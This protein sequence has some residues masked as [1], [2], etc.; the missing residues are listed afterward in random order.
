MW[1]ARPGFREKHWRALRLGGG[2]LLLLALLPSLLQA[3]PL[4][5]TPPPIIISEILAA[6]RVV[7]DAEGEWL[8]LA[9]LGDQPVDL[10]HWSLLRRD[11]E[12]HRIKSSLVIAPGSYVVLARNGN[13]SQNGGVQP[14][15]VYSGLSLGNLGD[16]LELFTPDNLLVDSIAWGDGTALQMNEGASLERIIQD[17][18]WAVAHSSWP[19]SAGD[20]G[21]PGAPYLPPPPPPTPTPLPTPTPA[22]T[23]PPAIPPRLL[24]SEVMIDPQ[25]VDD[26]QGEWVEL[27]NAD[28]AAV[29]LNGWQLRDQDHDQH[30]VTGDLWI[31]P[32]QYLVLA[33][34]GDSGRNG[35]VSPAYVYTGLEMGNEGDELGLVTPWGIE[36]DA[37]IWGAGMST[38]RGASLERTAP[39]AAAPWTFAHAPWPGSAGD[40]GSPGMPYSAP[41]P[42][43]SPTPTAAPTAL[44]T[45]LP[46]TWPLA[47]SPAPLQIDEVYYHSADA[48]FIVLRNVSPAPLLLDGWVI[49][50]AATPAGREGMVVLPAGQSLEPGALW[51]LA[52]S[53]LGFQTMWG[54][55][56]HAEWTETDPAVPTLL[57]HPALASGELALNDGGDEVVLLDPQGRVAD[58]VVFGSPEADS[59][60]IR[61]SLGVSGSLRGNAQSSLQ[62]LPDVPYPLVTD[63]RHRFMSAAP[64]PFTPRTLPDPQTRPTVYLDSGLLAQWGTLGAASTF[65]PEGAAPPHYLVAAAAAQGLDFI[66]V[67]DLDPDPMMRVAHADALPGLLLPAWR[68]QSA[69]GNS[70]IVYTQEIASLPGWNDLL[71][72]LSRQGALA[73]ALDADAPI[74]A[75]LALL[76]ADTLAVPS[77][78]AWLAARWQAAAMPLLPT[79]NA[80]PPLPGFYPPTPRYTGLAVTQADA[81]G[82]Q[83]A[84]LTRRGWLTSAPGLWLTLRTTDGVWM[85]SSVTASE[86]LTLDLYMGDR[87]GAPVGVAVW[88]NGQIVR[89]L[90]Q[91]PADGRW[92]VTLP[93]VPGTF[94]F[95]VATQLDGDFAVSAPLY[96]LPTTGGSLLLNEVLPAPAA[97]L[98]GDGVTDIGDEFIEL[99]NPSSVSVALA[100]WQISDAAGETN[101]RRVALDP[102]RAL[103]PGARLTLWRHATGLSL[104]DDGDR[105][106]LWNPTGSQVD[107]VA[108]GAAPPDGASLSRVPDG[109][110]WQTGT[111]PTPGEANRPAPEP[112]AEIPSAPPT[113]PASDP[114]DDEDAEDNGDAL[115]PSY[116]QASGPPASLA[117]AKL[118][119]LGREVEFRGQVIAPPGLF[120]SAVY[121][122]EAATTLDNV[123]LPVAGLGI[124]VYLQGGEFMPLNEGDWVLVRGVLR[125]FRGEMEMQLSEPGRLWPI[126]PG[127]PLLPLPVRVGEIG[128]SLEGRL[129]T[130]RGV[131]TGWQGDSIYLGDPADPTIAPVRITVRSSLGWKRP[132]VHKGEMFEVIGIVSQFAQE[133]PW[134]GGYRVL[135]RYPSDLVRLNP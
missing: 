53:A 85:G 24:L 10:H 115:S 135:V 73:Q 51:V 99:F 17:N 100:G 77:D 109:G 36:V 76:A 80:N 102:S 63:V 39:D 59:S 119:G 125:S 98:N 8:E 107:S 112:S 83:T 34:A 30:T 110:V 117:G 68:W 21:S 97:D 84:L 94:L 79:G 14:A 130:L 92:S 104:N 3:A 122:A 52:R 105:I 9:N 113:P 22:P 108:W 86:E 88:Q 7:P 23:P 4:M 2:A 54:R 31:A 11:G 32:G 121:V 37:L 118:Q 116:G 134:N 81:A 93:A 131:V 28:G 103:G 111:P 47:G 45:P 82:I 72:F 89:Q 66:A 33:R 64:D 75:H 27:V 56:P 25:A 35:G 69:A 62:Q 106:T 78:L 1:T 5:Q 12:S 20:H 96:V 133:A 127:T 126:G 49:G 65:S 74:D 29:N 13:L 18:T 50:D 114:D 124:Q 128:E 87:D 95:A 91:P 38:L 129:V 26:S 40:R 6:P 42:L 43:P 90:D 19:G 101:G 58:A 48:E 132:Y 15:Y 16:S 41:T 57:H 70:A 44:P 120:N 61:L 123:A 60:D 67:A 55:S 46:G 71:A